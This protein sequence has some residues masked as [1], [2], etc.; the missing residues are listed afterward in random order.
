MYTSKATSALGLSQAGG[1]AAFSSFWC[2]SPV[3]L[4]AL[5]KATPTC[6]ENLLAFL[7]H[8][9]GRRVLRQGLARAEITI[10]TQGFK[11]SAVNRRQNHLNKSAV[12][13]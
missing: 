2:P 7:N 10:I 8:E 5:S 4:L 6:G 1:N 3:E 13:G 11:S 9:L 12:F